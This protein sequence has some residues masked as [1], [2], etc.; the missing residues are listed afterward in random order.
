MFPWLNDHNGGDL[1]KFYFC[2]NNL[3]L[4]LFYAKLKSK[5]IIIG[6]VSAMVAAYMLK[7]RIKRY[8]KGTSP[9]PMGNPIN[10]V[11]GTFA[12]WWG[13]LGFNCGS[14]FGVSDNKW[15]FAERAAVTT[16][17][18]SIAGGLVALIYSAISNRMAD[19]SGVLNGIL[20]GLVAVTSG[21][22]FFQPLDCLLIGGL[23]S[24]TNCITLRIMDGFRIDDPVG[25]VAVHASGGIVRIVTTLENN[26]SKSQFSYRWAHCA[27]VYSQ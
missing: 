16:L 25:A 17:N 13:W 21:A 22:G 10:A 15:Q 26:L 2:H 1:K 27:L 8:E 19:V 23:G 11:V 18:G 6:G 20:A 14:T 3:L 7:P 24:I 4:K 9:L 5:K 12:L